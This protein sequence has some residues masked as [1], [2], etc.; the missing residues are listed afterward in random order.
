MASRVSAGSREPQAPEWMSLERAALRFEVSVDTL[1]RRVA[2]GELP[3]S[4]M[5]RRLIGSAWQTSSASCVPSPLPSG[6]NVVTWRPVEGS[7]L[8]LGEWIRRS[9]LRNH[10]VG[11]EGGG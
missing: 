11:S 1:R 6:P 5:G 3:A 7:L 4:R 9:P 8:F 10:R 2:A